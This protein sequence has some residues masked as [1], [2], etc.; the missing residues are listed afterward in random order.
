MQKISTFDINVDVLLFSDA[1]HLIAGGSAA[2]AP[3]VA[4]LP[5]V[6]YSC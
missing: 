5:V 4:I 3:S 1:V 2:H 6:S